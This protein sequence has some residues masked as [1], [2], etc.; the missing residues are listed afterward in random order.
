MDNTWIWDFIK[1]GFEI[2][3][4]SV[5]I[6]YCLYFLRGTRGFNILA[7]LIIVFIILT[8]VADALKLEVISWLLNNLWTMLAMAVVVIFQPELRRGL[9]QIGTQPFLTK[10]F[11]KE[12]ALR[13]VV[14]AAINM[15]GRRIGALMVFERD[16][17]MRAIVNEAVNINSKVNRSLLETIFFP[18]SP[19]HDGAVVIRDDTI[20]A[21]HA[22]MPL[23]Q[24]E[25][26]VRS[27]GT[28]HRAAVGI[29][30]ETDAVALVVSEETGQLSIAAR[31]RLRRDIPPDKLLRYLHM[32]LLSR[33]ND[34][35]TFEADAGSSTDG[36][37]KD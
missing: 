23:A 28:R 6:Y 21:A 32:L 25:D 15:S 27:L 17:G 22:I 5:I 19:L 4:I 3:L 13:E 33:N 30:A 18:N 37:S 29:S 9:A 1:P 36:F 31:G 26:S 11:K 8:A 34:G 35:G 12:E 20:V 14:Q 24:D 10:R 2:F 16:I 7:G